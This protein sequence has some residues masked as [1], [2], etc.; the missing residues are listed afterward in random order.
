MEKKAK[1]LVMTPN[2][3]GFEDGI[4]RIQ[5]CHGPGSICGRLRDR[6]HEVYFRD[7]ALEGYKSTTPNDDG[8]TVTIGENEEATARYIGEVQPDIVAISIL[9]SNLATHGKDI[10]RL[11]K[12]INPNITTI[13]GGNHVNHTYREIIR[14]PNVDFVIQGECDFTLEQLVSAITNN[15][16]V[17]KVP[18]VVHMS[19][20]QVLIGAATSRIAD[21]DTLPKEAREIMNMEGYFALGLFHS[22]KSGTNKIGSVMAS[23]G[24][25]E[26][27]TFCTTPQ[28]WGK[29]VRWRSPGIIYEEIKELQEVYGVEEIQFEDDTLTAHRLNL[30]ELCDLI[31]PLGLRWCTPNGVKV[32]YHAKTPERQA[33]L[34]RRMFESGCYQ[35][36]FAVESGDQDILDHLV[37]KKITPR[38]CQ[39]DNRC[40]KRSRNVSTYFFYG[41]FSRRNI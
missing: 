19:G 14:D 33:H 7:T 28:M 25:P 11:A 26:E 30:L 10:A 15:E 8:Q 38:Y 23:R 36:T 1:V 5:P 6:G 37:K 18:G 41:R 39:T 34:F 17:S 21:L 16:D 27:C 2:M 3:I 12:A 20:D 22:P 32:N 40:S 31:E 29:T 13:L 24:C 35:I 4:N 9:F